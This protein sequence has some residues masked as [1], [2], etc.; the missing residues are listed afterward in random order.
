ME[1]CPSEQ[2]PRDIFLATETFALYSQLL[3]NPI[4]YTTNSFPKHN[5]SEDILIEV[6]CFLLI[7]ETLP[8]SHPVS[9]FGS[10]P[11]SK[12][13]GALIVLRLRICEVLMSLLHRD[14][15]HFIQDFSMTDSVM[16]AMKCKNNTHQN[17]IMHYLEMIFLNCTAVIPLTLP[18]TFQCLSSFQFPSYMVVKN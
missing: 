15:L 16:E 9:T 13:F 6:D 4:E 5:L 11:N 7:S 14:T 2:I 12:F 10:Y 18:L 3:Q 17:V 1:K 8:V